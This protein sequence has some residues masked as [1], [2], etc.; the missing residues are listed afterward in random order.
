M[1][2]VAV[3][4]MH[5]ADDEQLKQFEKVRRPL[6]HLKLVLLS[7]S[8]QQASMHCSYSSGSKGRAAHRRLAS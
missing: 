5:Q 2:D 4:I 7:A 1:Q 8:V 3:K 6:M